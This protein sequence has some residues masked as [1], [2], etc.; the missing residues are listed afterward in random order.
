MGILALPTPY[1]ASKLH[2]LRLGNNNIA[3]G[4]LSCGLE[5]LLKISND[6]IQVLRANRDADQ[7]LRRARSLLLLVRELLVR[8]G[9]RAIKR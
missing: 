3:L 4:S 9:R 5:R 8:R 7:V 6:V 1:S 2:L